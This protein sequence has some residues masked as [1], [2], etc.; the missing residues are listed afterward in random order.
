MR[1]H[2][3]SLKQMVHFKHVFLIAADEDFVSAAFL[4]LMNS[5]IKEE[6]RPF[7]LFLHRI[8]EDLLLKEYP[9][10]AIR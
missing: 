8:K 6:M 7:S 9:H 10:L 3:L 4:R 2:A 1:E 5:I